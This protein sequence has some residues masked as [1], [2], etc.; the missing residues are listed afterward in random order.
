MSKR[1]K[2]GIIFFLKITQENF[3]LFLSLCELWKSDFSDFF[4][5][6]AILLVMSLWNV[7]KLGLGFRVRVYPIFRQTAT[8]PTSPRPDFFL[9]FFFPK[10]KSEISS[11]TSMDLGKT[12]SFLCL[13]FLISVII[14]NRKITSFFWNS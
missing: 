2:E 5:K 6:W 13:G 4:S 11:K 8:S 12:Y 1:V 3:S 7:K 14:L 9:S 10:T